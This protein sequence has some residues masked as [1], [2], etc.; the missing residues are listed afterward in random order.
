MC[1]KKCIY[2]KQYECFLMIDPKKVTAT[3]LGSMMTSCNP[4]HTE[5]FEGNVLLNVFSI[6][7]LLFLQWKKCILSC[8]IIVIKFMARFYADQ[9]AFRVQLKRP[10][11]MPHSSWHAPFLSD[12]MARPLL[13]PAVT[14]TCLKLTK[15]RHQR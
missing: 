3:F 11:G 1:Y 8:I 5:G 9:E 2:H 4:R 7:L 10:Y 15:T 13:Q 12:L 6:S 14:S